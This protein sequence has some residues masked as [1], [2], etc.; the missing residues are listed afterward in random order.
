MTPMCKILSETS[1]RNALLKLHTSKCM[2]EQNN[3]DKYHPD[4]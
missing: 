4:E 2:R 1:I 3:L